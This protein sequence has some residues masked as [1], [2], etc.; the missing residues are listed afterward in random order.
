MAI[1]EKD[2]LGLVGRRSYV[3]ALVGVRQIPA[4]DIVC[5]GI[6]GIL[7]GKEHGGHGGSGKRTTGAISGNH[8][9]QAGHDSTKSKCDTGENM[10]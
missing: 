10:N 2:L 3:E 1:A 5:R 4:R 8:K 6:Y 9:I 7:D